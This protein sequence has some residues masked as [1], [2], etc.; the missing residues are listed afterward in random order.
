MAA[1]PTSHRPVR[2][3]NDS[4]F[5]HDCVD[6]LSAPNNHRLA[7]DYPNELFAPLFVDFSP[8][9]PWSNDDDPFSPA[10][11]DWEPDLPS[12]FPTYHAHPDMPPRRMVDGFVDLTGTSSPP[13]HQPTPPS[14]HRKR[15]R[16]ET[17]SRRGQERGQD[18]SQSKR[19]RRSPPQEINLVDVETD[20]DLE[21]A[22]RKQRE[23][24]VKNQSK[25]D[26]EQ[27]NTFSSMQCVICLDNPKDICY[28]PC[29]RHW[30]LAKAKGPRCPAA[31]YVAH[32]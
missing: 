19:A 13:R 14:E 20:A 5:V 31:Q 28:T 23:E 21:A 2:P 29:A 18:A 1:L 3:P 32:T 30:L 4:L 6:P 10:D 17:P 22:L 11:I 26:G 16:E 12:Y 15:A 8:I 24:A 27:P 7:S 9:D 25:A